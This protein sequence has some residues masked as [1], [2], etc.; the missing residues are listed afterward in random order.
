MNY[1][2]YI[3]L[4]DLTGR[5][6]VAMFD[7]S[8]PHSDMVPGGMT[9]VSAGFV[10]ISGD[11]VII[12]EI[13]SDSLGLNPLPGDKPRLAAFINLP[14]STPARKSI[15]EF[16]NSVFAGRAERPCVKTPS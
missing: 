8:I 12:P 4:R 7:G 10:M 13:G 3:I 14:F 2:K 6:I 5:E 1:A 9:P 16:S 11:Q 15:P